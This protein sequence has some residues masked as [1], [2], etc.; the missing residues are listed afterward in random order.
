MEQKREIFL[1][2]IL[3]TWEVFKRKYKPGSTGVIVLE[4]M[5]VVDSSIL[6]IAVE[7][8]IVLEFIGMLFSFIIQRGPR[9]IGNGLL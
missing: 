4:L 5:I 8:M 2:Q 7:L 9:R 3:H 1:Q 6:M